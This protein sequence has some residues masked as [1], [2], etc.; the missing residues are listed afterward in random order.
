MSD[1]LSNEFLRRVRASG[2]SPFATVS[3]RDRRLEVRKKGNFYALDADV[4]FETECAAIQAYPMSRGIME[5]FRFPWRAA[6]SNDS[7]VL[8]HIRPYVRR[9]PACA[10]DLR[11]SSSRFADRGSKLKIRRLKIGRQPSARLF[12]K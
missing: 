4:S 12:S 10:C 7:S 9:A 5:D 8:A 1:Y 6:N 3:R 2:R 11:F